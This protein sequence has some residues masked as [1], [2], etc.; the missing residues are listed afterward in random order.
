MAEDFKLRV[1]TPAGVALDDSTSTVTLPTVDG[2]IGV[3]PHHTRY[4]GIIGA[5]RLQYDKVGGGIGELEISGGFVSFAD[6]TLTIL[7]DQALVPA[8]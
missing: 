1:I 7:A 8:S 4:T 5:G 3:L 6:D 2:Q